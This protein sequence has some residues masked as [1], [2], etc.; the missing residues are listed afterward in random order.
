MYGVWI[1]VEA[2]IQ[3]LSVDF[4]WCGLLIDMSDLSILAD[5]TR[6]N[7]T[8]NPPFGPEIWKL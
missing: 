1:S 3:V 5:Y 4:P 2:L 8:G 7:G 6:Y